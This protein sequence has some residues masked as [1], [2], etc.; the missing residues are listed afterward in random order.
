MLTALVLV[1]S[2]AATPDLRDCNQRN[3]VDVLRLGEE[4]NNPNQCFMTGQ[5]TVATTALRRALAPDGAIKVVCERSARVTARAHV[6]DASTR[7]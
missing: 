1:C 2:L 3:A 5:A 4:F 7:R 6:W